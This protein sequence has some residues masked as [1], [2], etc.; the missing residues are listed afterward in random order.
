MEEFKGRHALVTGA[1]SG[2][3]R[4]T[5]LALA[6]YGANLTIL[7]LNPKGLEDTAAQVARE[8]VTIVAL[9]LDVS[10]PAAVSATMRKVEETSGTPDYL[11]NAAGA[12][13]AGPIEEISDEVLLKCFSI[14]AFGAVYM[15]RALLPGMSRRGSGVIVNISSLHA[16]NGQPGA[17]LYAAAKGAV[18]GFTK[19]LA[20]EKGASGIRANA[21]AP[22]PIDTPFW[23]N[24]MVGDDAEAAIA[25]R[26]KSIPLGRLGRPEDVAAV[27]VFLLSSASAYMTGQ[28]VTVGGGEIMP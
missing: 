21:V 10:D 5:A 19:S 8:G 3:G 18:M 6:K 28:V 27:I 7:D 20:R 1:A 2:I 23:R 26:V 17:S 4:A 22:G 12:F 9:P 15:C 11:V 24:A 13:F 14:N 25:R 16:Q